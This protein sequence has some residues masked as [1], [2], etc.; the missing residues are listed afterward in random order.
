M[1][2]HTEKIMTKS[3]KTGQRQQHEREGE[4]GAAR[5]ENRCL[6]WKRQAWNWHP[7]RNGGAIQQGWR[8]DP[9]EMAV[10]SKVNRDAI[11][12]ERRRMK[13]EEK[14]SWRRE[15]HRMLIYNHLPARLKNRL[16]AAKDTSVSKESIL[17]ED[18]GKIILTFRA[19]RQ[20]AEVSCTA[21]VE[22]K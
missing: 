4:K 6:G 9:C 1:W 7:Y 2:C 18:W 14:A 22:K 8:C 19:Y 15:L 17:S 12:V 5:P 21:Q 16:F 3:K 11:Q 20:H 10:R 13:R